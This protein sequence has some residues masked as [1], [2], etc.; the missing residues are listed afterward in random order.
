MAAALYRNAD[1]VEKQAALAVIC[2]H[3]GHFYQK[4]SAIS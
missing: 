2:A 1:S 3:F 4:I